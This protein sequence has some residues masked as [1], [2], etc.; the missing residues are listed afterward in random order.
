MEI[1][2]PALL[3]ATILLVSTVVLGRSGYSSFG[4]L[5]ESW[6]AM[7]ARAGQQV[8]TQLTITDVSHSSPYVDV[9]LRNDGSTSLAEFN[10]MDVLVEY[11]SGTGAS[12]LAWIPYIDGSQTANTWIVQSIVNDAFEPG[13]LNPSETLEMRIQLDPTVGAGTTNRLLIATDLGVVVSTTFTG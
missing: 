11:T 5:G 4:E 7:E 2:I 9:D 10:R 1:S 13:I 3:L 8:R 12:V 6:K